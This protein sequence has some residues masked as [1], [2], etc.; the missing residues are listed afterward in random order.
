MKKWHLL[1]LG[2]AGVGLGIAWYT[3][4]LKE[5]V[6]QLFPV[7]H[8]EFLLVGGGGTTT[9]TTTGT[10]GTTATTTTTTTVTGTSGT[11]MTTTTGVSETNIPDWVKQVA[12]TPVVGVTPSG[13]T[14]TTWIGQVVGPQYMI[15][16]V[17]VT[18]STNRGEVIPAWKYEG[19]QT[20][21][22]WRD[23]KKCY[24][25]DQVSPNASIGIEGYTAEMIKSGLVWKQYG[26]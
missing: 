18:Y 17:A 26:T 7:K 11:A 4:K 2:I 15:G 6:D 8:D 19:F 5:L 16:D 1:L 14:S 13:Y 21:E 12:V 10:S 20:Y 25:L 23:A 3:G 9:T 24:Y 22:A